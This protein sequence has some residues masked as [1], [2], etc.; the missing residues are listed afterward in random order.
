MDK[1]VEESHRERAYD[2]NVRYISYSLLKNIRFENEPVVPKILSEGNDEFGKH[3]NVEKLQGLDLS[4]FILLPESEVNTK[5]KLEVLLHVTQQLQEIDKSGFV[6]FDRNA[7]NIRVLEWQDKISTRQIDLEEYYDKLADA[8]YSSG[9]QKGYDEM[10]DLLKEKNVD[11]WAPSV[12]KLV[13]HAIAVAKNG[14]QPEMIKLF[15]KEEWG[16]DAKRKGSNLIEHEQVLSE[17]LDL[18]K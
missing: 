13:Y 4:D 3:F 5:R 18:L 2:R 7:G 10:V 14:K 1:V 16:P 9:D 12:Q 15:E 11:L 17:A 6:L 8:M